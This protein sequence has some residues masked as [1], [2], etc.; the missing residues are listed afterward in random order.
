MEPVSISLI[1]VCSVLFLIATTFIFLFIN[2]KQHNNINNKENIHDITSYV[3]QRFINDLGINRLNNNCYTYNVELIL[4]EPESKNNFIFRVYANLPHNPSL[5]NKEKA[6]KID[7]NGFTNEFKQIEIIPEI[8]SD[9][10][11]NYDKICFDI[12]IPKNNQ[13]EYL[14]KPINYNYL[15]L[16]SK[17]DNGNYI[18]VPNNVCVKIKNDGA[19]STLK[20]Q[21]SVL[22]LRNAKT[23]MESKTIQTGCDINLS[24][25]ENSLSY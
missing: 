3:K 11:G 22:E 12:Q 19:V 2:E 23:P 24:S 13:G 21:N 16:I 20:N 1:V 17:S 5:S 25:L 6:F 8:G 15:N 14:I 9:N 4:D 10:N 7:C 18:Q